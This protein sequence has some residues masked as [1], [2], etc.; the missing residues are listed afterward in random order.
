MI[1]RFLAM[2]ARSTKER[3]LTLAWHKEYD[4]VLQ[5]VTQAEYAAT[6]IITLLRLAKKK[7][8]LWLTD[9]TMNWIGAGKTVASAKG[10]TA[11]G[12]RCLEHGKR[13]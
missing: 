7:P 8:S 11:H 3:L 1:L 6:K 2:S 12:A 13:G 4:H 9:G 5:P 10:E